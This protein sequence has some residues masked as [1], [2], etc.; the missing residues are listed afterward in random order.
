MPC[1]PVSE[2]AL[3]AGRGS[4]P[5][6]SPWKC[7]SRL[8]R[9]LIGF[10][11]AFKPTKSCSSV[12]PDES[13]VPAAESCGRE[14]NSLLEFCIDQDFRRCERKF[15]QY[16][17]AEGA[18]CFS[19]QA[20]KGSG[21]RHCVGRLCRTQR[22]A[23]ASADCH[24]AHRLAVSRALMRWREKRVSEPPCGDFGLPW[25]VSRVPVPPCMGFG[26]LEAGSPSF[27]S[28]RLHGGSESRRT[29]QPNLF[30][31]HGATG[32]GETRHA[33]RCTYF[34]CRLPAYYPAG[35]VSNGLTGDKRPCRLVRQN[36]VASTAFSNN[37]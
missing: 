1:R 8:R 26:D 11:L 10:E 33:A 22:L 14:R 30:F 32:T 20:G 12:I 37:D 3:P 19:M 6:V 25:R 31:V 36:S 13:L 21:R 7:V 24:H 27:C 16:K 34:V 5:A 28:C 35:R 4:G 18:R 9:S 15:A 23:T 17:S 29:R 2:N